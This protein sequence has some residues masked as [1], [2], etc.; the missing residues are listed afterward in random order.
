MNSSVQ[1]EPIQLEPIKATC[2]IR[3]QGP[4]AIPE[5]LAQ[6]AQSQDQADLFMKMF[7][8]FGAYGQDETAL[9]MQSKAL[10]FRRTFRVVSPENPKIKLLALVAAGDMMD[11]TPLDFLIEN[12]DIQLEL[13]YVDS[14]AAE[15]QSEHMSVPEHDL[16]Y[17]ALGESPKNN[18]ILD[19]LKTRL[20]AWPRPYINKPEC[21][22]KC[23]RDV[24]CKL[25]SNAPN[26]L[27]ANTVKKMR[28]EIKYE[29]TAFTIRP[30]GS[31][32]GVGFQK[33]SS[34]QELEQYLNAYPVD[35]LFYTAEFIDYKSSDGK[36]RKYRIAMVE[37]K[38]FISHLAI[39]DHWIVHYFPSG[40]E[41]SQSKRE[42]ERQA[43]LSFD[44]QFVKQ[45]AKAFSFIHQSLGL[46]YVV[47]DCAQSLD[48]K[49]IVFEA[50]SGA[51]VHA[52]D[53]VELFPYKP[54]FMQKIFD[55]FRE[56][57]IRKSKVSKDATQGDKR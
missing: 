55:A 15:M 9:Q 14:K 31:H 57:L 45:H 30:I 27:V 44:E 13:M 8:I 42:E 20:D 2:F 38:P 48:G 54:L 11:N 5:M 37:G 53:P 40:M 51:W 36:Y 1:I 24:F 16:M 17:V 49:L 56:M 19:G 23:A 34:S 46:D 32:A 47:L 4:S 26:T 18:P 43:M 50:D 39:S 22:K 6:A 41:L 29:S 3:R 35:Q 10:E 25:M 28:H 7:Y 21:I 12:S 33:I 52:T